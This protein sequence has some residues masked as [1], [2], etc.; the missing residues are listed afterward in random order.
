MASSKDLILENSKQLFAENGFKGTTIAQIAKTSNVTDAAIYRHYTSKQQIFDGIVETFLTDYRT[1]LDQIK[2]RQK[3][4]YCLI[5]NLILDLCDFIDRRTLEFK[6]ILNTYTTIATAGAAMDDVFTYLVRTVE[7][8]L[9]RGMRDGTVREDLAV[10]ETADVIATLLLG[11]NRRRLFDAHT[12]ATDRLAQTTV[13][14]CQRSI[15]SA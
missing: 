8:C 12:A 3:S 10:P 7:A 9:L 15:K 5:E 14:F 13:A 2:E 6:V 4:G 11:I 1:L